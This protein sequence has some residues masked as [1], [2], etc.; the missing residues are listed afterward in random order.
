MWWTGQNLDRT[1]RDSAGASWHFLV[2]HDH[3]DGVYLQ[4]VY[5]W[6]EDRTDSGVVELGSDA[7]LHVK[8]LKVLIKKLVADADLRDKHHRRLKWPVRRYYGQYETLD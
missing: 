1:R 4:R 3:V 8:Q 6:N 2:W 5:F 7:T